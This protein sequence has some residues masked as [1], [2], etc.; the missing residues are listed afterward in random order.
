MTLPSHLRD[1]AL[2]CAPD[3]FEAFQDFC[4]ILGDA[5]PDDIDSVPGVI[6]APA[7]PHFGDPQ[8][9]PQHVSM[10]EA[11]ETGREIICCKARQLGVTWHLEKRNVFDA[12]WHTHLPIQQISQG[13]EEAKGLNRKAAFIYNHLP[14]ELQ[15][16][17]IR[18]ETS[19]EMEWQTAGRLMAFPSTGKAT[20]GETAF[21]SLF[22][23]NSRH[24]YAREGY[25][26][27]EAQTRQIVQ[28]STANG[29]NFFGQRFLKAWEAGPDSPIVAIFYP[30][31]VRPDRQNPDGSPNLEWYAAKRAKYEGFDDDFLAEYPATVSDAF[32]VKK[33]LVYTDFAPERHVAQVHPFSWQEA[34][35]RVFGVDWGGGHPT[36]MGVY[37]VSPSKTAKT[38]HKFAEFHRAGGDVPGVGEMGDWLLGWHN[39]A[40]FT[41]GVCDPSQA[42]SIKHLRLMGLP[43]WKA[44]NARQNMV[45]LVQLLKTG[46]YSIH[47]SCTYSIDEFSNYR[48]R[49][50]IDPNT[51]ENYATDTP[52]QNHGDH[53][54]EQR[55]S[56]NCILELIGEIF[57]S[58]GGV[59]ELHGR[60][61]AKYA[62]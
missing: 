41:K 18:K 4:Y 16:K 12:Q 11:L 38:I 8:Y 19:L 42:N 61:L 37:G 40:P 50:A 30:W 52:V 45:Q 49:T 47:A 53:M 55:Y 56:V 9:S 58:L 2:A 51:K 33:G 31:W 29:R 22:D 14:T 35:V 48:R 60:K 13:E 26:A 62:V 34:S 43:A 57:P 21:R 46:R 44:E 20:R 17:L 1:L 54:D 25:S 32:R 28:V 3:D 59:S 7:W 6:P 23:E 15:E 10:D 36:A 39:L 5:D 24:E 27:A